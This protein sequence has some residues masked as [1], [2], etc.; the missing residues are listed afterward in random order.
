MNAPL[1]FA[2][3]GPIA[4][5]VLALGANEPERRIVAVIVCKL[6][7]SG[8][9]TANPILTMAGYVGMLAGWLDFEVRARELFDRYEVGVLHA[10]KFYDTDGDFEGWTRV[11]KEAFIRELQ[12][13]ILGRLDFGITTS[14]VKAEFLRIKRERDIGH[15][16]S[17][18]GFCLRHTLARLLSDAVLQ[19]VFD[20][21]FDLTIIHESGDDN[22]GDIQRVFNAVKAIS[23]T[24]NR[25][26]RSFGFADKG[27]TIGLQIGDF[28]A[29]TSRKYV[30]KYS[31]TTGYPEQPAILSILQDR[32]YLVDD[33]IETWREQSA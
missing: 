5:L 2:A 23:P 14:L 15:N 33:V 28:L 27:S 20:K 11:R 12:D 32:I 29:V 9:D 7:A 25:R 24:H 10:K 4:R 3:M 18:L 1:D 30:G 26:L 16:K 6:D 8:T 17:P 19:E 13:C 31:A 21:G 22:A